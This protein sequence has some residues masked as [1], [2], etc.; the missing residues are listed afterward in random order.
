[1]LIKNLIHHNF[2]A[3]T[4]AISPF[5]NVSECSSPKLMVFSLVLI[6]WFLKL[7][8]PAEPSVTTTVGWAVVA[9]C[10]LNQPMSAI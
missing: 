7:S 6:P 9:A 1:M 8:V 5:G 3:L 4:L 2:F 10:L